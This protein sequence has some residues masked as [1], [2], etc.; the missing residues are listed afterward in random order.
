MA[1]PLAPHRA[2]RIALAALVLGALLGACTQREEI[3]PGE[4][5]PVRPAEAAAEAAAAAPRNVA[6]RLPAARNSADWSH[7]NGNAAH[8]APHAALD[9][10]LQRIWSVDIGRGADRRV[11]LV[12]APVVQDNVIYT[13]DAGATVSAVAANGGLLWQSALAPEDWPSESSPWLPCSQRAV[14]IWAL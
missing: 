8:L 14:S 5:E 6:I 12:S 3:L 4:R 7:L 1:D 13:L 11:R 2:P 9:G 10:T